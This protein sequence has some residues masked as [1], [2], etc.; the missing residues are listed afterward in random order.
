MRR[1][2]VV[3]VLLVFCLIAVHGNSWYINL[4][5]GRDVYAVFIGDECWNPNTQG[6]LQSKPIYD[7]DIFQL[8]GDEDEDGFN[9]D[10]GV[11]N[12]DIINSTPR[13]GG[14]IIFGVLFLFY[15][16]ILYWRNRISKT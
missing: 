15:I 6:W 14:W 8:F 12:P 9:Y 11:D 1:Y 16:G 4:N 5:E 10:G 7:E 3:S 2:I 13:D